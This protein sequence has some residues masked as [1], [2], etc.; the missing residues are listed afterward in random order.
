MPHPQFIRGFAYGGVIC[1]AVPV[2]L[3]A[4]LGGW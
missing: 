2:L 1:F 3:I 4:L